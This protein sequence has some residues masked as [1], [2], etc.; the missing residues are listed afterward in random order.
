MPHNQRDKSD[1]LVPL[2]LDEAISRFL[3]HMKPGW[4]DSTYDNAVTR[5]GHFTDWFEQAEITDLNSLNGRHLSD[6]VEWRHGE[7][8]PITL[9]KQLSTPRQA[10]RYWVTLEA[11][12]RGLAEK[13]QAPELPD[14]AEVSNVVIDSSRVRKILEYHN[15]Y[16]Y[17]SRH[18]AMA[19]ILWRT[20]MRRGSLHSLDVDDLRPDDHAL[21]LKHRPE[22]D[23]YLKNGKHGERWVNLKPQYFQIIQ[24]YVNSPNRPDVT[25]RF[26][27]D[28]LITTRNGRPHPTTLTD[29]TY[30]M[31]RPCEYGPCPVGRVP[32]DCQ[33]TTDPEKCPEKRGPH[34]FRRASISEHLRHSTQPDIVSDRCNVSL[35]VLYRHYDVRTE[36]EK[37]A[38]RKNQ[39]PDW[40]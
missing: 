13:L 23:T 19:V 39:L 38:V 33:G 16:R 8:K 1:D 30:R 21:V 28:P 37:M 9:Q 24:D 22:S 40:S 5:L 6:F 32:E 31:T 4:R 15:R 7:V 34:A 2:E 27:R 3:R 11:V 12:S 29:N 10:L 35:K 20:G 14:G 26:G 17:A 36:R 25:D 18:H